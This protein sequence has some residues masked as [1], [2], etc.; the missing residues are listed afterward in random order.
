MV[1]D[2]SGY[3]IVLVDDDGFRK[4]TGLSFPA[5]SSGME[6]L[7]RLGIARELTGKKR[8]RVFAYDRYLAIL[9]EGTEP[10]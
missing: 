8:D 1:R 9:S 6:R 7:V 2:S 3:G 4:R 10:L 5:T